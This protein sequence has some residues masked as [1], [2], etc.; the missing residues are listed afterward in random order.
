MEFLFPVAEGRGR[1]TAQRLA[2]VL[3]KHGAPAARAGYA[4]RVARLGFTPLA[5]FLRGFVDL[6]FEHD[7]RWYVVDWKSNFLGAGPSAYAPS[8]VMAAMETHHYFLQYQLYLVALHRHLGMRLRGYDPRR[9]LGGVYYLFLRGMAPA[10]PPGTGIF[11]DQ[12]PAALVED[13]S[14]LLHGAARWS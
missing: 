6:V 7:G 8:R 9:H 14:E 4:E 2:A 11:H 13:L 5:G 1:L 12:P 3:R 10:H